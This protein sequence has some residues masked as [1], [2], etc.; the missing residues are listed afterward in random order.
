MLFN[1]YVKIQLLQ[2]PCANNSLFNNYFFFK[3]NSITYSF[4]IISSYI[5][6]NSARG[7]NVHQHFKLNIFTSILIVLYFA[8]IAYSRK[9]LYFTLSLYIFVVGKTFR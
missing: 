4:H 7:K 9:W 8:F 5:L 2:R 1:R 3:T 6:R